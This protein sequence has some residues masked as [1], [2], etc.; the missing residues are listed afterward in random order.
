MQLR[1][2]ALRFW[3]GLAPRG[4]VRVQKSFDFPVASQRDSV[5][6]VRMCMIS[7]EPCS[8]HFSQRFKTVDLMS[9]YPGRLVIA[10]L[11]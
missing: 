10:A 3:F 2:Q 6:V 11:Q 7:R 9:T 4:I 5:E 8:R 1:Q